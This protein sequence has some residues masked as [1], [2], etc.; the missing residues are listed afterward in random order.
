MALFKIAKKLEVIKEKPFKLEKE[1]QSLTEDN[2]QSIFNLKF[3]KSE[4]AINKFRIDTL[5]FDTESKSFVIIEYKRDKNFSVI[6]TIS[7]DTELDVVVG[8]VEK[9]G[10]C[11]GIDCTQSSTLYAC[12]S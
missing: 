12:T 3:V 9:D 6:S 10:I 11:V 1:I 2:L 8:A 4:F 7:Q 5:A